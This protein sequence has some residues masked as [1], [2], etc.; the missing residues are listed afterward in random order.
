MESYANIGFFMIVSPGEGGLALDAIHT[1]LHAYP[2]ARIWLRDDC[3][4]DGTFDQL[5]SVASAHTDCVDL[6]RNPVSLG[7]KGL[8]VSVFRSFAHICRSGA[9]LEMLIKVDPDVLLTGQDIVYYAQARFAEQGPGIIGSYRLSA[10]KARRSNTTFR[11]RFLL[12]LFPLGF[13]RQHRRIRFGLPFYTRYLLKAF[14]HG[15]LL[16]RHVLGAFYIVHGDTLRALDQAGFWT[17]IPEL[18][19]REMKWDDALVGIGPW[20]VGHKLID[21]HQQVDSRFW[22][23]LKNPLP[24]SAEEI[25]AARY[26]A[27]HPLK[28]DPAGTALR[29]RLAALRA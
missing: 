27:V 17:S 9:E 20:Y 28:N 5:Q 3:T 23:Q 1:I 12:D 10:T 29:S 4:R 2:G 26:Q 6:V 13:D 16:G 21:L 19:S 11:L 22:I 8:P 24:L 25:I 7:L 14:R 15:Y 18:G